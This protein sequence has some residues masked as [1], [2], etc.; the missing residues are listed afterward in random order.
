MQHLN[1]DTLQPFL[2]AASAVTIVLF[3]ATKGG[4]TMAQAEEFA[5]LWAE[6]MFDARF[7][8]I[9]VLMNDEA[10]TAHAIRVLPTILVFRAGLVVSRLE[11]FQ[12]RHRIE[13]VAA[14]RSADADLA[15]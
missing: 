13:A 11:G 9:D 6:G 14:R 10:R 8:Y 7:A 5:L 1:D 3:G 4:L 15:A 12:P 2:D